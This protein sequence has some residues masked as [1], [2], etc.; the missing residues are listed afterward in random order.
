ML[1]CVNYRTILLWLILSAAAAVFHIERYASWIA[2]RDVLHFHCMEIFGFYFRR[3]WEKFTFI[4]LLR[5]IYIINFTKLLIISRKS[6]FYWG[7]NEYYGIA[8]WKLHLKNFIYQWK[9]M[10]FTTLFLQM[11][12]FHQLKTWSLIS[13]L[14]NG[15]YLKMIQLQKNIYELNYAFF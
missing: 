7:L 11:T 13:E 15:M 2:I 10:F 4:L 12:E 8:L 9:R 14:W 3:K 5:K 1:P 6:Y